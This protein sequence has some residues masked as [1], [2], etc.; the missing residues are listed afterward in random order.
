MIRLKVLLPSEIL[1]DED[2]I[3]VVAEGHNGSFCLLPRHV[4]YLVALV[5]GILSYVSPDGREH[6][7]AVDE[8]ILM[9]RGS[10][11]LVSVRHAVRGP[12]LG[13]LEQMVGEQFRA[14]EDREAAVRLAFSKL[15]ASFIHCFIELEA[16]G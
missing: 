7:L 13:T 9:K 15:E 12:D 14:V 8:G 6:F 16:R 3:K 4:D 10:E 5:P 2:V 1:V 11:T